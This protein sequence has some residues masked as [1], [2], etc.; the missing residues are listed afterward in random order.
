[1]TLEK[2]TC[3]RLEGGGLDDKIDHSRKGRECDSES[4]LFYNVL[5][6]ILKMCK[7][8]KKHH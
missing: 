6:K 2:I 4:S 1:M 7:K 5:L 3:Q 8:K